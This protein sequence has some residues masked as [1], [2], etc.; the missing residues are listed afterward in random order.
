MVME[1]EKIKENF[2]LKKYEYFVK[3]YK[4]NTEFLDEMDIF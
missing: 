1:R 4:N 3:L 2:F